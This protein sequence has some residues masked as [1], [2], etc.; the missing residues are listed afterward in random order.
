M[1]VLLLK[2][3]V[4]RLGRPLGVP[5]FPRAFPDPIEGQAGSAAEVFD[6][7]NRVNFWGS[8][9]SRTQWRVVN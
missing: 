7:I 2:R 3:V 1:N 8:V 9:R 5:P 6:E 4:N